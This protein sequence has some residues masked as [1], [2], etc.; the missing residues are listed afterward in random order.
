MRERVKTAVVG[1]MLLKGLVSIFSFPFH[2]KK[3]K[4]RM[5]WLGLMVKVHNRLRVSKT[6]Y[7]AVSPVTDNSEQLDKDV[8]GGL[9]IPN[10]HVKFEG[11]TRVEKT[12][13][14]MPYLSCN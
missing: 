13:D 4:V 10:S 3:V 5:G 9:N 14:F 11:W 6:K 7:L 2:F 12:M 1:E 8:N